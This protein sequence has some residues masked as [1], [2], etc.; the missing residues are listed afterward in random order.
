MSDG[1]IGN[2]ISFWATIRI[3][4][5]LKKGD[6]KAV[7]NA[8]RDILNEKGVNGELV[9]SV[10]LTADEMPVLSISMK[11]STTHKARKRRK[12]R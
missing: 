4:G 5:E 8:I 6:L 10:R 7:T 1:G 12:R 2:G 11:E 9:H 3:T